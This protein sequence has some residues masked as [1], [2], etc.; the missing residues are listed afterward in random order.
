MAESG[1]ILPADSTG[2]A[3][4]SETVTTTFTTGTGG[5]VHQQVVSVGDPTTPANLVAVDSSGRLTT[6][7]SGL[8]ITP[9][10]AVSWTSATTL[11]TA[12]TQTVSSAGNLTFWFYNTAGGTPFTGTPAVAFE[13][14]N[15]GTN[16][17][18]LQV[19]RSDTGATVTAMTIPTMASGV[20]LAMDAAMEGV[21]S[22]RVRLTAAPGSTNGMSVVANAGGG[23]FEPS[24]SVMPG[25]TLTKGT[26]QA[27]G[28]MTQDLKDAGRALVSYYTLIPVLTSATDTLQ[29]LTGTKG[30][31]TVTATAT[32]A[33][34]TAGKT[35]R[36]QKVLASYVS[37]ATSGYAMVRL[38]YNTGGV[39]AITSPVMASAA[40]GNAS[41]VTANAV[42]M[43][44]VPIPDGL[45]FAAGTGIGV[46]VQGFAA[47]TATAVGYACVTV[48]GYEY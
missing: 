4:R 17:S 39:V 26:Q 35:F 15:D 34:V 10:A 28:F 42:G 7:V 18:P 31:A 2:K 8:S 13:Q 38:R 29:T 43:I 20:A 45:E 44:E 14:S 22:A 5:V 32:P 47:V 25:P 37:T 19:V 48:I 24:V 9:T 12:Y 36:V 33:V 30:N 16:W 11:N 1:V 40:V 41:P 23:M 46:S 27:T 3:L 21:V 6:A